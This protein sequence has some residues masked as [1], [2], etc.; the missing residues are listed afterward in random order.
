MKAFL[1]WIFIGVAISAPVFYQL[2]LSPPPEPVSFQWTMVN[3]NTGPQQG[4]AHVLRGP[5]QKTV[6]IDVGEERMAREN[7]LPFLKKRGYTK[8]EEILIT[9]P[10]WDHY[11]GLIPLLEDPD[12]RI[13][14]ICMGAVSAKR[15]EAESWTC[16]M[17]QLERIR[18]LAQRR[19]ILLTDYKGWEETAWGPAVRLHR[20]FQFD[21]DS[22]PVTGGGMNDQ[23]L[24]AVLEV[25]KFR[26]LFTGDL[27][28][29]LSRWIVENH[30]DKIQA[31]ILK[32]PH[33]GVESLAVNEFF[34]AVKPRYALVP[35]PQKT[36]CSERGRRTRR[37]L[38]RLGVRPMVNGFHGNVTVSFSE[39]KIQ[40]QPQR[41]WAGVTCVD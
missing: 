4:D 8:I 18:R 31:D 35:V 17:E 11:G 28:S 26:T 3:V 39:D 30:A 29:T 5:G 7:L 15:C 16:S 34:E 24:I 9:H 32:V 33:H 36:W 23:S 19:G 6:L 2:F 1:K 38:E 13:G 20:L 41:E 10:H 25:G 12:F 37:V 22:L 14:R 21:E 40:I 27:N